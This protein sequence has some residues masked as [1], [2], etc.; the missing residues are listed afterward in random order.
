[1]EVRSCDLLSG[2]SAAECGVKCFNV[3]PARL[4]LT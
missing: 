1:M 4:L 3:L 2:I